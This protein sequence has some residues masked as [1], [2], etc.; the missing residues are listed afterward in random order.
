V[1]GEKEAKINQNY[2]HETPQKVPLS[3]NYHLKLIEF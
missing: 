3:F 2:I 1:N